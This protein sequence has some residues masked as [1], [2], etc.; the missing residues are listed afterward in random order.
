MS[1]DHVEHFWFHW[2]YWPS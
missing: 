2:L 1:L